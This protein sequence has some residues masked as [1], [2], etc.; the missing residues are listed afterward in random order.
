MKTK[1]DI[2]FFLGIGGIGMSALARWFLAGGYTI[3]GYDAFRTPLTRQLEKEGMHVFYTEDVARVPETVT[4][5]I[6]TPAISKDHP[7]FRYFVSQNVKMEKRAA[8]LGDISRDLF[9]IAIAGTHGKTSVTAMVAHILKEAGFPVTAF[10]GGIAKNFQGNFVFSPDSKYL[11]AEADEYDRS[12]LFLHPDVAVITSMDADH[13]DIYSGMDDLRK[14]FM[15]FARRLPEN[16]K[17]VLK[18]RLP[19]PENISVITYGFSEEAVLKAENIRIEKERYC[20]DVKQ[21][22]TLL[23]S[24]ALRLPGLH[25]VENSLAATG[26]ALQLGIAP[27]VIREALKS[28]TGVQRRFDIRIQTPE[29]IFI[30]DYAH[31]PE[32]LRVTLQTVKT[33]YPDKKLTVVFQP[34]LYSR[35]RDF[36]DDFARVLET[37][38]RIILLD[39]YPAR[40]KPIPG[41]TSQLIA[42]KIKQTETILMNKEALLPFLEKEKPE[43]LLTLGAGDIGLLVPDIEKI[44][45]VS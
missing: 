17:L 27:A 43:L 35:T 25:Y 40:E 39:I 7:L 19:E 16:G 14:T 10:I 36:V 21:N 15:Q 32:E 29:R 11:V 3:Y 31:H 26:V 12:Y 9:T 5:V 37:A 42:D 38:D 41:I 34:H 33:L 6:Y 8:V 28:F 20:F 13:L 22:K 18:E 30:D 44:L 2:L 4:R 45:R 1:K 23:F 24:P